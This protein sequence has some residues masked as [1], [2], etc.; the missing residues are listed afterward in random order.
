MSGLDLA[1]WCQSNVPGVAVIVATGYTT[2]H[3]DAGTKVLSK[4]YSV[5]TL[6]AEL[7]YAVRVKRS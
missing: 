5:E 1:A 7:Q 2:Q 4:P 3:I 6:L